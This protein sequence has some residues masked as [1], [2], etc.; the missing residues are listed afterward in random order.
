MRYLL[1]YVYLVVLDEILVLIEW[2]HTEVQLHY[3]VALHD[4]MTVEV[5]AND[6]ALITID[7]VVDDEPDELDVKMVAAEHVEHNDETEFVDTVDEDDEVLDVVVL[8]HE[9]E[10][11]DE[12]KVDTLLMLDV[13]DKTVDE[14]EVERLVLLEVELVT[15][16]VVL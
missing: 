9:L 6:D 16:R 11:I 2:S 4:E 13:L 3:V 5:D 12:V 8:L 10:K 7:E 15:E 14:V 1:E